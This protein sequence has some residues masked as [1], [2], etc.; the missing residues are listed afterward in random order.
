MRKDYLK[1]RFDKLAILY[2][3][4]KV[5]SS[6]LKFIGVLNLITGNYIP[7]VISLVS[8]FGFDYSKNKIK[9]ILNYLKAYI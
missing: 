4:S 7:G 8:S 6:G 2:Y 1:K 3:L 9:P 5:S